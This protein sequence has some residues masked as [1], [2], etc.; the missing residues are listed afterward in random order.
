MEK[1]NGVWRTIRGRRIFIASGQ[2]LSEA[3]K[4]SG[5]FKNLTR[6]KLREAKQELRQEGK[7][8][9]LDE[10][11]NKRFY[12]PKHSPYERKLNY[13]NA[14]GKLYAEAHKFNE[15]KEDRNQRPDK[16]IREKELQNE[17]AK[18]RVDR[19]WN[20]YSQSDRRELRHEE[21]QKKL[22]DYRD[23]KEIPN[24]EYL[25]KYNEKRAMQNKQDAENEKA[26][27]EKLV[28]DLVKRNED[29]S[30]W[31]IE[32]EAMNKNLDK[33]KVIADYKAKKQ[34][35]NK[36]EK[37]GNSDEDKEIKGRISELQKEIASGRNDKEK[38]E[39]LKEELSQYE[40]KYGKQSNNKVEP[41]SKTFS[42]TEFEKNLPHEMRW[43]ET[44][45]V[46]DGK[47]LY[48]VSQEPF[49]DEMLD[50][51]AEEFKKQGRY[52]KAYITTRDFS[53]YDYNDDLK[54][55]TMA[56][57]DKKGNINDAGYEKQ[58]NKAGWDYRTK[59]STE[60]Y[61][62]AVNATKWEDLGL[63]VEDKKAFS[64]YLQD[65]YGTDDFKI[66]NFDS[67]EGAKQIYN[68]YAEKREYD[69]VSQYFKDEENHAFNN[70]DYS[71]GYSKETLQ[72]FET[73]DLQKYVKE[74]ERL[75][76]EYKYKHA[77]SKMAD[78]RKKANKQDTVWNSGMETKYKT[79]Y[80]NALK[81]VA[82]R[83]DTIKKYKQRKGK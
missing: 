12:D 24:S 76:N 52:E 59:K 53:G 30:D 71:Y 54:R 83:E 61:P 28:N 23:K 60:N 58:M 6:T 73:D 69:R 7:Q 34:S 27:R 4:K 78:Q 42:S 82:R 39:R 62:R 77:Q 56:V 10:A 48:W 79:Q 70:K 72:K 8:K 66:I 40:Q 21:L 45:S 35:N 67:K 31:D 2:S 14:K 38:T 3:M 36:I 11:D 16:W 25:T 5:K 64:D 29:L 15:A 26:S 17:N 81:E 44:D 55:D 1:E 65:K 32:Q 33:N 20:R 49:T 74:Q 46:N 9:K 68:D 37:L 51:F 50:K 75:Y 80:E 57:I 47:D 19:N 13:E 63:E 43:K 41:E 22:A 18:T